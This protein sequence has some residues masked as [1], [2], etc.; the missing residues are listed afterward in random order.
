MKSTHILRVLTLAGLG[1]LIAATAYADE[2]GFFYGGISA[3]NARS[4][5]DEAAVA[6]GVLG[7][8]AVTGISS[9][10]RDNGYKLFGGYQ[11]NRNIGFEAGYFDLGKTTFSATAPGGAFNNDTRMRGLNLDLVGTLPITA[12]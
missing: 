4:D 6:A 8:A 11:L 1:S 7:G 2:P 12:K 3:G 5:V 9:D 10:E